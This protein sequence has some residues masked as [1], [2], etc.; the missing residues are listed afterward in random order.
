[1]NENKDGLLNI[2]YAKMMGLI[3]EAIK[4]LSDKIDLIT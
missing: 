4:E 3:V 2:E 1:V